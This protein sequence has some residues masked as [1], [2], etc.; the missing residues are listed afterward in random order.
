MGSFAYQ[1]YDGTGKKTQG[2]VDAPDAVTANRQ[3]KQRGLTVVKLK[4][5]GKVSA[6]GGELK[7]PGI[8]GKVKA[9][10]LTIF[11]RQFATMIGSGLTILRSLMILEEQVTSKNLKKVISEIA[12][13]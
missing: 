6:T 4:E 1:A 10:D 12:S 3:L 11:A 8:G 13:D 7:I 2:L 5:G 9:K